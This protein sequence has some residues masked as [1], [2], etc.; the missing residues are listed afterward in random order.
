ML[1]DFLFFDEKYFDERYWPFLRLFE[2]GIFSLLMEYY[3]KITQLSEQELIVFVR[4]Q[5]LVVSRVPQFIVIPNDSWINNYIVIQIPYIQKEARRMMAESEMGQMVSLPHFNTDKFLGMLQKSSVFYKFTEMC[6]AYTEGQEAGK[7][8]GQVNTILHI[9]KTRLDS[10]PDLI[11]DKIITMR[12]IKKIN[13][14]TDYVITCQSS[15]EF[16]VLF[17]SLVSAQK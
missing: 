11:F 13:L 16:L 14:L 5:A 6:D 4:E 1:F 2:R 8:D 7:I 15:D 9:L 10:I 12:D 17:E 3:P